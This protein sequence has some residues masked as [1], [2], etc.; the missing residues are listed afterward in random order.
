MSRFFNIHTHHYHSTN[1]V[2]EILNTYPSD[3]ISTPFF[4]CGLHPWHIKEETYKTELKLL[5]YKLSKENCL[6]LGECGLDKYS[7][8][9]FELQ[10]K[11]F[12]EQ[13]H[14]NTSHQKPIIIHCVK[15]YQEILNIHKQ[16]K[17]EQQFLFHGFRKNALLLKQIHTEGHEVS[18]GVNLMKNPNLQTIFANLSMERIFLETDDTWFSIEEIYQ[19]A[20]ELKACSLDE[21]K[22]AVECNVERF[23]GHK[24]H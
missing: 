4:T 15:A 3:N 17:I 9:D 21:L 18:F 13:L 1:Q 22:I 5:D 7:E 8:V 10:K 20:A 24:F 19:K 11:V 6:A 14:L 2:I 12:I 16:E 23:F